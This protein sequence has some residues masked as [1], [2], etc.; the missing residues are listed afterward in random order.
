MKSGKD[1]IEA[2]FNELGIEHKNTPVATSLTMV[3]DYLAGSIA[4]GI[5]GGVIGSS[6]AG[7]DGAA[8]VG[9]MSLVMLNGT[10]IVRQFPTSAREETNARILVD[11]WK[12]AQSSEDVKDALDRAERALSA[13]THAVA[14]PSA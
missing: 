3:R 8:A 5:G 13:D 1:A 14:T 6:V 2:V 10:G 12:R 4:L 9:F 11:R 7:A